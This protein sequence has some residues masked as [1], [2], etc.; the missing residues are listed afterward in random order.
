MQEI[1]CASVYSISIAKEIAGQLKYLRPYW[2][3]SPLK[4]KLPQEMR[5]QL[6][7]DLSYEC[8]KI[9]AFE[10]AVSAYSV[11][12]HLARDRLRF[13][14]VNSGEAAPVFRLLPAIG[15]PYSSLELLAI[16]RSLRYSD[17]FVTMSF[18][19]VS[20]EQLNQRYDE[21]GTEYLD[22][23]TLIPKRNQALPFKFSE[24]SLL[25]QEIA[26]IAGTNR[27]LLRMD[28]ANC[29][30]PSSPKQSCGIL[31]ALY[32]LCTREATNVEW[33]NL[34]GI[35]LSAQDVDYLQA[36]ADDRKS[37]L[38]GLDLSR[39]NLGPLEFT[40]ILVALKAQ[41]N[42]FEA[43]DISENG[44]VLDE[45]AFDS[46]IRELPYLRIL[47]LSHVT[48]TPTILE[49]LI[50]LKT[51]QSWLLQEL[52]FSGTA[53][54]SLTKRELRLFLRTPAS[55]CLRILNLDASGLTGADIGQI[56]ESM[57]ED[58]GKTRN[59][60][61]AVGANNIETDYRPFLL[62]V[63]SGW[64]S[65]SLS[66]SKTSFSDERRFVQLFEALEENSTI[67]ALDISQI[68][69]TVRQTLRE[70]TLR[71]IESMISHNW[72]L[73]NLDISNRKSEFQR[74]QNNI[75]P[76]IK[77]LLQG[78]RRNV[79]LQK[80]NI[81]GHNLSEN[82][83]EYLHSAILS[84]RNL[85]ELR[86][87][88]VNIPLGGFTRIVDAVRE[89]RSITYISDMKFSQQTSF[90][91]FTHPSTPRRLEARRS[92][93]SSMLSSLDRKIRDS[94][95]KAPQ[96]K[97]PSLQLSSWDIPV[98]DSELAA[99]NAQQARLAM[100]LEYNQRL[101]RSEDVDN[102]FPGNVTISNESNDSNERMKRR[103]D[104]GHDSALNDIKDLLI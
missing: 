48:L 63:R 64:T 55:K 45:C 93:T 44:V 79:K 95:G 70:R 17:I 21:H 99:W 77:S 22:W 86:C 3:T 61:L 51:F 42:T 13:E 58:G 101:A 24:S 67:E 26:A 47:N 1:E 87:E 72:T 43:L 80:I 89:S 53:I 65:R 83:A 40:N 73:T 102:P 15:T 6:S 2:A 23:T 37:H 25:V 71:S 10:R 57:A 4:W 27:R 68:S 31:K 97:R 90:D 66:L 96:V 88:D 103:N 35:H 94:M 41:D 82:E 78:L 49:P 38:H 46:Q 19:N 11:A 104:S 9:E 84:N 5:K 39:T 100:H 12:Y 85:V 36:V 98:V 34:R 59:I 28:F 56:L 30:P 69:M 14:I 50:T 18:A 52:S 29:I 54:N 75:S 74:E 76:A 16:L 91:D 33:L 32:P 20:L 7:S 60:H 8:S 81:S 92:F 62:A